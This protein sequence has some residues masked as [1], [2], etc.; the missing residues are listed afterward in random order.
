MERLLELSEDARKKLVKDFKLPVP[1]VE[2]PHFFHY[3]ALANDTHNSFYL[4]NIL[5]SEV[6]KHGSE[7]AFYKYSS[8]LLHKIESDIK[9]TPEWDDF[10][11]EK[12][13]NFLEQG[14]GWQRNKLYQ[15]DFS[16]SNY[17]ALDMKS[18][19]FQALKFVNSELVLGFNTYD[20]LLSQYTDSEY[21]KLNKA[22]RKAL[23]G[24]LDSKKQQKIQK[25]LMF[26]LYRTLEGLG[27]DMSQLYGATSD[28][29][30]I[31]IVTGNEVEIAKKALSKHVNDMNLVLEKF[32]LDHVHPVKNFF[33]KVYDDNSFDLKKV[34]GQFI[35]EVIRHM[36][37][38]KPNPNDRY[39]RIDGRVAYFEKPLYPDNK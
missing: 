36:K 3:M 5:T 23:F 37:N 25:Y 33:A 13:V 31:R 4:Y 30:V 12:I 22:F 27:L 10:S 20:E 18:A 7:E 14:D 15:P 19:N 21:I 11:K 8:N 16:G 38:Q 1:V 2:D 29:F 32:R 9:A 6:N 24:L 17:V 28:E 35:P 26:S 39:F 34:D